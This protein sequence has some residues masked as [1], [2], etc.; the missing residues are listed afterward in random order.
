MGLSWGRAASHR[1]PNR[2]THTVYVHHTMPLRNGIVG[3][4]SANSENWLLR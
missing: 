2:R 1:A 4:R 3:K